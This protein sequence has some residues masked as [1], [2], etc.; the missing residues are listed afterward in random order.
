M[1]ALDLA[2]EWLRYAKSDINTANHMFY[3]VNPKETEISC[4]HSQQ[5]A[6][7]SLKAYLLLKGIQPPYTHD[8]I[9]LNNLCIMHETNFSSM[10]THCV[11]LNPYS[12][13]VKYPNELAVDEY[14]AKSAIGNAKVIF[15]F[16][17]NLINIASQENKEN[18]K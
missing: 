8:L 16:C 14:M 15:D 12:V 17:E 5:C 11:C 1:S 7:K 9:E 4:Y 2:K 3:D 13:Q 6:E 10:Q 18:E